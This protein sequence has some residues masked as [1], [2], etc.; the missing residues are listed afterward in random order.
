MTLDFQS[1]VKVWKNRFGST[2]TS[3][4]NMYIILINPY[5]FQMR[6]IVVFEVVIIVHSVPRWI[7]TLEISTRGETPI[8]R[9]GWVIGII[10]YIQ[11]FP[12]P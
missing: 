9:A 2:N 5:Q 10:P 12:A 3:F 6:F 1:F 4:S 7:L 11:L 8:F